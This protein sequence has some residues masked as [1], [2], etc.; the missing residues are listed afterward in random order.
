MK[1]YS[2][3]MM[4]FGSL[5]TGCGVVISCW[6]GGGGKINFYTAYEQ[7]VKL[8]YTVTFQMLHCVIILENLPSCCNI[9]LQDVL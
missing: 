4:P 9:V 7:L 8:Q 2:R 5:L 3:K 6:V 1:F